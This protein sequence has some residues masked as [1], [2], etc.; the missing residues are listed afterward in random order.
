MAFVLC[1]KNTNDL[2]DLMDKVTNFKHT[3]IN[4]PTH[5]NKK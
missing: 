3:T 5:N 1:S 4:A 2:N